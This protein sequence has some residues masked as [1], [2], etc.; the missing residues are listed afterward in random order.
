MW[1]LNAILVCIIVCGGYLLVTRKKR[2]TLNILGCFL[3]VIYL[4]FALTQVVGFPSISEIQRLNSLN[5][6]IFNPQLN[7]IPFRDGLALSTFLNIIF[8]MPLGFLLPILWEPFKKFRFT[9]CYLFI[10]SLVIEIG[11]LFTLY[12]ASDLEDLLMNTLGGI[13]GWVLAKYLFKWQFFSPEK[14][15]LDWLFFPLMVTL[16]C[17]ILG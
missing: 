5:E 6:S 1:G 16:V 8:F 13:I 12:R 7:F 11:Q 14:K 17:F 15:N 10:F 9:F 2:P 3:L 4:A